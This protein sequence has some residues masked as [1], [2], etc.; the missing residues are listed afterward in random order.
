MTSQSEKSAP[1][2]SIPP[3]Y[4]HVVRVQAQDQR[5][6][7]N[8][9]TL[10]CAVQIRIPHDYLVDP[11]DEYQMYLQAELLVDYLGTWQCQHSHMFDCMLQLGHDLVQNDFW[12]PADLPLLQV[13]RR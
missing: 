11:V 12:G 3:A 2:C 9:S 8:D 7:V 10:M 1:L 6:P 4:L 13:G 5:L